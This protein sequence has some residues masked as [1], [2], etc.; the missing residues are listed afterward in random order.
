MHVV[1][2]FA[3]SAEGCHCG[4]FAQDIGL[5]VGVGMIPWKAS[6]VRVNVV[7]E[8]DEEC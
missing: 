3:E 4:G 1:V 8:A 5:A 7:G 6:D 2:D